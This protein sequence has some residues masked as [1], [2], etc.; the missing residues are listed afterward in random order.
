[1]TSAQE[2]KYRRFPPGDPMRE[3]ASGYVPA[4]V[5]LYVCMRTLHYITY[6]AVLTACLYHTFIRLYHIYHSLYASPRMPFLPVIYNITSFPVD[7]LRL[8]HN[9]EIRVIGVE[10]CFY[11]GLN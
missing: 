8:D 2:E 11:S 9:F 10:F 6:C 3:L 5:V 7:P 4:H 1:M